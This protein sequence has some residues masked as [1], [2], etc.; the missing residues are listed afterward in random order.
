M[1]R[2]ELFL[3]L[4]AYR[5]VQ[6]QSVYITRFD[7]KLEAELW[8]FIGKIDEIRSFSKNENY[9]GWYDAENVKAFLF[10]V[11]MLEDCYPNVLTRMRLVMRQWGENW[12]AEKRQ[13]ETEN[14]AYF[15]TP[16]TDDTLC[17]MTERKLTSTD[18]S[19]FLLV[20][21]GA[22]ACATDFV[23][24]KRG[25]IETEL[26]VVG[27]DI[28]VIAGWFARNRRPQRIFH[29]NPKHGECGKG[30]YS[31]NKG[32]KVS[33]LMCSRGKAGDMLQKAIG[34]NLRTL[35]YFDED[36]RR[37]IE[38]KQESEN[39]YHAFHLDEEDEKRVPAGVKKN[40]KKLLD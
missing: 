39:I 17:E 6:E 37:Y 12:R 27:T 18:D 1:A 20:N 16:I 36:N 7:V 9:V 40:I 32:D 30:A 15:C 25:S 3:L 19:T 38:F 5:E 34:E 10:P 4:P 24:T 2:S 28:K 13:Q 11:R 26:E 21:H 29:P 35:Y 22:F 33:V 14:Y 31:D 8:E 23:R